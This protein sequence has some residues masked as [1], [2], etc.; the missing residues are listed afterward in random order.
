MVFK[1][2][3]SWIQNY[4]N[5]KLDEE[6]LVKIMLLPN[7]D[8]LATISTDCLKFRGAFVFSFAYS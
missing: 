7:F 4:K 8:S 5:L 1:Q 6:S 2:K 3:L